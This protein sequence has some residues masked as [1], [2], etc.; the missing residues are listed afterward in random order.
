M[1]FLFRESQNI[2]LSNY[3]SKW[4]HYK[5]QWE[6]QPLAIRMKEIKSTADLMEENCECYNYTFFGVYILY[7]PVPLQLVQYI[8]TQTYCY[9]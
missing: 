8:L 9:P 2:L 5:E 4:L 1:N 6:T 7:S 3:S